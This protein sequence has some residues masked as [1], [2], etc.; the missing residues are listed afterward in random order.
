MTSITVS[1]AGITIFI[2]QKQKPKPNLQRQIWFE[3]LGTRQK[4]G[5][6]PAPFSSWRCEQDVKQKP[7][8]DNECH[9]CQNVKQ[10]EWRQR[11]T[12][13]RHTKSTAS[14]GE[15]LPT[16]D[17]QVVCRK[18]YDNGVDG[19]FWKLWKFFQFMV[20]PKRR[21]TKCGQIQSPKLFFKRCGIL[22]VTLQ[23]TCPQ[24]TP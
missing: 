1:K 4:S 2:R 24:C 6:S 18:C 9:R 11:I 14:S 3:E 5:F 12:V 15:T 10:E 20:S 22:F 8:N 23:A 17:H 13:V 7:V 21:W 19:V 16:P